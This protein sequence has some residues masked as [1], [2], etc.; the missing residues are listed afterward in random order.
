MPGVIPSEGFNDQLLR[1]VREYLRRERSGTG[2]VGRWHKKGSGAGGG[3]IVRGTA[4]NVDCDAGTMDVTA[5]AFSNGCKA[6]PDADDANLITGVQDPYL[7]MTPY[8]EA[9]LTGATVRIERMF[10]VDACTTSQ[11]EL[12]IV[13]AISGC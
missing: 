13:S 11:W 5:V 12:T 7:I 2:A 9:E 8:T 1:T 10:P 6:I 4:S 3:A